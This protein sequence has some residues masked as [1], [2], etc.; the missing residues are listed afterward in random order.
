MR[1]VGINEEGELRV[2]LANPGLPGKWPLKISVCMGR[3]KH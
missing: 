3:G 2:Q 1:S